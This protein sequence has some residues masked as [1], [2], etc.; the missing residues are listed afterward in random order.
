MIY[1]CNF[2]L[3][4]DQIAG[5]T[6]TN[7][8]FSFEPQIAH[9]QE[10][11]GFHELTAE[12]EAARLQSLQLDQSRAA[13]KDKIDKKDKKKDKKKKKN[14]S[15]KDSD[16]L[17]NSAIN[18]SDVDSG[19]LNGAAAAADTVPSEM[20]SSQAQFDEDER[21]REEEEERR[22]NREPAVIF[23]DIEVSH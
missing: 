11:P 8:T 9:R 2:F 15:H 14:R 3:Y 23:K 7:Q 12:I 5:G 6:G 1:E 21:E 22:K 10:S 18:M 17:S 20:R 19:E 16:S 13:I 4:T